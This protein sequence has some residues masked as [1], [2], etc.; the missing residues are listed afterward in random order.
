MLVNLVL[1]GVLVLSMISIIYYY[2]NETRSIY[3]MRL[4]ALKRQD[5]YAGIRFYANPAKLL[6]AH[7]LNI[8]YNILTQAKKQHL[9]RE[10]RLTRGPM[11]EL[12]RKERRNKKQ[13]NTAVK[14]LIYYFL[15]LLV[16]PSCA[17]SNKIDK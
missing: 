4:G 6:R 17:P 3:F 8:L 1:I 11:S 7:A 9:T 2:H 14:L 16:T 12:E 5:E 13:P 15:I 10:E